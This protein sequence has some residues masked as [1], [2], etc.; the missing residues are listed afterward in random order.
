MIVLGISAYYHDSAAALICDGEIIA[1]VQEERFTRIKQDRS[2]PVHAIRYCLEAGGHLKGSDLDAVVYYDDPVLTLERYLYNVKAVQDDSD[3]LVHLSGPALFGQK[4]WIEKLLRD[5]LGMLGRQDRLYISRHHCSHAASAFYPSQFATAAILTVDGVGEWNTT[6]ISHGHG[7]KIDILKTINYPHSLGLLYSAFT[8]FCGFKVN[9]GDYKLMGLAPYGE[10]VYKQL[11]Y[12]HLIDVKEDGSFRMNPE[13]FDY[14]HGRAMTN[15]KFAELFGG[16]ERRPEETITLREMNIAASAQAVTEEILVRLARTAARLTKEKNLVMAGGVALNCTANGLLVREKI[17]DHIWIQPA[18]GDAGG[19]L[20]AALAWYYAQNDT[21]RHTETPDSQKGSFLGPSYTNE[22]I[23]AWLAEKHIPAHYLEDDALFDTVAEL[24]DQQKVI[25]LLNGRMEY[26]PRALGHRSIIGDPRSDEM[27]SRMNLRIKYRESFR[28]FAPSVL[29]ERTADYFDLEL[30]SPYMLFCCGVR[31]AE[32][33]A[34]V[35]EEL[36]KD[37][38]L[39]RIINRHRS[40][41]P[42]ITHVDNS[43]RI[44]TVDAQTNPYFHRLI[45]AFEKR[46]GCGTVINTSFNVRGEPI[47]CTPEDAYNCF[48]NTEMDVLV[49]ENHILY[50][51]EQ[52][53]EKLRNDTYEPD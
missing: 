27:Q 51:E 4:L 18:A 53:K 2:L 3:D 33:P 52:P 41:V 22:Q 11:I 31:N 37:P 20:G 8:Y 25:G 35:H 10:P 49:M 45:K 28:P 21:V 16:R 5:E 43:A 13:Y 23:A 40:P 24:L 15:A 47:V 1:A 7:K 36:Q 42:A 26:G 30:D 34:N 46:T 14:Q 6:T 32:D 48:M 19:A 50:K 9:S 44:Q 17:F 29:R 38:D 12:D 39:I